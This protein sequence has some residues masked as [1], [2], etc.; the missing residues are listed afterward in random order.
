MTPAEQNIDKKLR[1]LAVTDW[2]KFKSVTGLDLTTYTICTMRKEGKSLQ[3][4][5]NSQKMS[6]RQVQYACEKCLD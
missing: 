6:K 4:I 1:E 3:Q 5:A 2:E